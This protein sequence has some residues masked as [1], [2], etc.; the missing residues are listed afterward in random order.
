MFRSHKPPISRK[1]NPVTEPH[2]DDRAT[3]GSARHSSIAGMSTGIAKK[4][5]AGV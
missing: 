5:K 2:E 3:E 4:S 1:Y